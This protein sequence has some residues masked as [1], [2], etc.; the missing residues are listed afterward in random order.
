MEQLNSIRAKLAQYGQTHLLDHWERL[1]QSEQGSL[2]EQINSIDFALLERLF[3]ERQKEKEK[4]SITELKPLA[5]TK[6]EDQSY[7]D[8]AV[9]R[10]RGYWMLKEGL[11]GALL[12]AGGQ[13]TR[14]GHHAPKGT[15]CFGSPSGYSLFELQALRIAHLQNDHEAKIPWL[16]M[17]SQL[18]DQ[19]TREYFA[20]NNYF[21][22]ERENIFFF[23]QGELPAID[24]KGKI[25]LSSPG[26]I[27]MVPDGNGGVF[28]ALKKSGGLE[29]LKDRGCSTL[30]LYGVDNALVRVCDPPLIG[31]HMA[32]QRPIS[33]PVVRKAYPEEKVGLFVE[34]N[35]NSCVA[36]YTDIPDEMRFARDPKGNLIFDG[37]NLAIHILNLEVLNEA[38][39]HT[40][41]YHAAYKQIDYCNSKG[42]IVCPIEPNGWKF[43]QYM[44]DIFPRFGA[45]AALEVKRH[46][47]FAPIK[48]AWGDDSPESATQLM[49]QLHTRWLKQAGVISQE[50]TQQY[51]VSPKQSFSGGN[52]FN[53]SESEL[54]SRGVLFP[55]KPK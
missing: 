41:P 28:R 21:G 37:S 26:R 46:E 42:E 34:Y 33:C 11:V 3:R 43:E 24:D 13:G 22:L 5:Y 30:Y 17:T 36:E 7:D 49:L 6:L 51:E 19:V 18:N 20:Q 53:H 16:I 47:H 23:S 48:N 55:K 54:L 8:F 1:D 45:M 44:F 40:L 4:L 10:E 15:Y 2:L 29:W 14:L 52:L 38:A 27:A 39:E 9:W 32:R 50:S 25:F 12:V 31:F 35:G